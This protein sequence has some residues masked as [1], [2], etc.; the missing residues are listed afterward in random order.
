VASNR[1]GKEVFDNSS[2]TFYGGSF[3]SGQRGEVLAQVRGL[4]WG[5]GFGSGA[6]NEARAAKA[7]GWA[8]AAAQAR[9]A[10]LSWLLRA[11]SHV[12][13][14]G[15]LTSCDR[16]RALAPLRLPSPLRA[17]A[18]PRVATPCRPL[19]FPPPSPRQVGADPSALK[20]GNLDPNPDKIEGF[21]VHEFDLD[22]LK[23]ERFGWVQ[24]AGRGQFSCQLL[25]HP[26]PPPPPPPPLTN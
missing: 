8:V 22:H 5:G 25:S 26:V 17:P 20:D 15:P 9:A 4:G 16:P 3:I 10:T 2:I 21:V 24:G 13:G 12:Q 11:P 18:A 19:P 6:G 14:A 23:A 1:I 7:P